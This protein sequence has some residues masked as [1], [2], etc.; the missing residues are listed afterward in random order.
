DEEIKSY[1]KEILEGANLEEI[2][3]KTVC[4]QVYANY[5]DFDLAHKKDFIKTTVKSLIST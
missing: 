4:K 5:P 3:M 2:T 1:V